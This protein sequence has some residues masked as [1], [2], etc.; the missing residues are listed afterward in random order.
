MHSIRARFLRK[1]YVIPSIVAAVALVGGGVAFA[2]FTSTGTGAG[3]AQVGSVQELG[4]T[5][6]GPMYDSIPIGFT[7]FAASQAFNGPQVEQLGNEVT[8]AYGG[9]PLS[10]VDVAMDNFGPDTFTTSITVNIYASDLVL[11]ATDTQEVAV[12]G[13]T[14][15]GWT[16]CTG[17]H[18]LFTAAFPFSSHPTLPATVIYG[19]KLND[20][21][22]CP[23][24]D[25]GFGSCSL[26]V[27]SLNVLLAAE[28]TNPTVGT[29]TTP[30]SI[31]VQ[32]LQ[33][34]AGVSALASNLGACPGA[35][36]GVLTAF[37]QE[38]VSCSA[39][40]GTQ[41]VA[42]GG[43]SMVPAVEIN[44]VGYST[45]LLYPGDTVDVGSFTVTNPSV[46]AVQV[47]ALT[48]GIANDGG[49]PAQIKNASDTVV[50]GCYTDWFSVSPSSVTVNENLPANGSIIVPSGE[51]WITMANPAIS[52]D[53]CEGATVGLVL[54]SS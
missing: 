30:G 16:D 47:Q 48:I 9:G 14:S 49:S 11:L 39:G 41:G 42:A 6:N 26:P 20:L 34:D 22:S 37:T 51:A 35:I 7:G 25:G 36:G 12:P 31:W 44:A 50:A 18:A 40:Y 28:P 15:P 10:D 43:T 38:P 23:A 8:L 21:V 1:R 27:G 45:P 13:C 32:S 29:D 52:Q 53:L 2:F 46:S 3:S 4:I 5:Q 33:A 17:G 54:G 24:G 19:I